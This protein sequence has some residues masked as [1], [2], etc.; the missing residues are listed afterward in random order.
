[1]Q[2][3]KQVR[4]LRSSLFTGVN[5]A[6]RIRLRMLLHVP[7]SVRHDRLYSLPLQ[8]G[9]DTCSLQSLSVSSRNM[10]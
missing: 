8:L 9:V 2:I 10:I 6:P 3:H 1:M 7:S 5:A 4:N